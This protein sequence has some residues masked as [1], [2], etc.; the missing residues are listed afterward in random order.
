[1][2]Q[3]VGDASLQVPCPSSTPKTKHEN[4]EGYE[5]DHLNALHYLRSKF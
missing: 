1:M 5:H 4:K 3:I 2:L